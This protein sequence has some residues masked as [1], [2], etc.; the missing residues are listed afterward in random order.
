MAFKSHGQGYPLTLSEQAL[1]M[2]QYR[3]KYDARSRARQHVSQSKCWIKSTSFFALIMINMQC[4]NALRGK[5]SLQELAFSDGARPLSFKA[6]TSWILNKETI[7][8]DALVHKF[9][10]K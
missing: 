10:L 9:N 5:H 2:L 1:S 6:Q 7:V 3:R 4:S 8:M